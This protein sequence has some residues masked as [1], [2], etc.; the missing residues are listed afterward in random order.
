M[1]NT[2]VVASPPPKTSAAEKMLVLQKKCWHYKWTRSAD[3]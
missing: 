1:C 3:L 2:Q